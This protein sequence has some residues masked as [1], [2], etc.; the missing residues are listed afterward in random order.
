VHRR[1]KLRRRIVLAAVH[2]WGGQL[3]VGCFVLT[4]A[5]DNG[6]GMWIVSFKLS[7]ERYMQ[8]HN[9][10]AMIDLTLR[11]CPALHGNGAGLCARV[12]ELNAHT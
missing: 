7:D 12:L 5:A 6:H 3:N 8:V 4:F 1:R 10:T 11:M 2:G 9:V